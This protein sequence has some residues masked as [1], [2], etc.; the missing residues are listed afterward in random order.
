MDTT[1]KSERT[2]VVLPTAKGQYPSGRGT[3]IGHSYRGKSWLVLW[4]CGKRGRVPKREVA[5]VGAEDFRIE[6]R[7]L[8]EIEVGFSR[9]VRVER[10]IDEVVDLMG[11]S[12]DD[13]ISKSRH[14]Q[15]V[16]ARAMIVYLARRQTTFSF[17]QIAMMLR[18]PNHSTVITALQ[19]LEVR[20]LTGERLD[21]SSASS[22]TIASLLIELGTFLHE[23]V[24]RSSAAPS[25]RPCPSSPATAE[26]RPLRFGS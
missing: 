18:R 22:P 19:R 12:M 4:E 8:Q 24:T 1:Q 2:F 16:L 6:L 20:L 21:D 23:E 10:I 14:R 7:R 26:R 5:E 9:R 15:V 25:F 11:V 13:L 17:P 3:I